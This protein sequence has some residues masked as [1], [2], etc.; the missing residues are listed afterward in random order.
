M[1]KAKCSL[2]DTS[3]FPTPTIVAVTTVSIFGRWSSEEI[4]GITLVV[5]KR[6]GGWF[7]TLFGIQNYPTPYRKRHSE[8]HTVLYSHRNTHRT[9]ACISNL[10]YTRNYTLDYFVKL[11]LW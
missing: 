2:N 4:W 10:G 5:W 8:I 3:L 9:S 11:V 1:F 6:V 7:V